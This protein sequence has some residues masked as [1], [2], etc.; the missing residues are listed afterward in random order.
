MRARRKWIG[1]S[2]ENSESIDI[3][4][5]C[6]RVGVG[7]ARKMV[8]FS[9]L[10]AQSQSRNIYRYLIGESKTEKPTLGYDNQLKVGDSSSCGIPS[11]NTSGLKTYSGFS[12]IL[13]AK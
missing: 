4:A 9:E 2:H 3:G 13:K 12:E 8:V 7:R 10:F 11:G 6:M 1:V 5:H